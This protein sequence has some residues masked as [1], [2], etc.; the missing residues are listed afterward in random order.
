[1]GDF[2]TELNSFFEFIEKIPEKRRYWQIRTEGGEYFESF[3]NFNYVGLNYEEITYKR[4]SEI[5]KVS[6]NDDD[7]REKLKLHVENT[8]PDRL[9][10]L[11]TSQLIKFIYEVKKGDIVI[12]PSE[13]SNW[14]SIGRITDTSLL[15]ITDAIINRTECPYRKRKSVKWIKTVPKSSADIMLFRALQSHQA[16]TE[17]SQHASI[18]ERSIQD[19]YKLEDETNLIINVTRPTNIPAPDLFMY[20]ADILRLTDELIKHFNL[21]LNISDVDVKINLNSK[22][23]AQFLS[24]NGRVVLLIGL[25]ALTIVGVNG[26]GLKIDRP[27]FKLD[28]TTDGI[29][30]K[31]ID[32]QNSSQDRK[33]KEEL[34]KAQDTLQ[35]ESNKDLVELLKQF[36][37]NKDKSK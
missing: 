7:F 11:I 17:V 27:G 29:I 23:K 3:T 28:L 16:L 32:Y 37:E 9:S 34:I 13:G 1:M 30:S 22:G 24:K 18:I 31:I 12:V 4:I 2:K 10:G 26:G 6:V 33:M 36:S 35:I 25:V 5:K 8:M 20:G 14:I 19:F 21:D 15:E